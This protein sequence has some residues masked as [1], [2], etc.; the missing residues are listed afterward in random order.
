MKHEDVKIGMKV[1]PHSKTDSGTVE[2]LENSSIWKLAKSNNQSFLY[3]VDFSIENYSWV[4]NSDDTTAWTT[5]ENLF[6]AS[7]FEPYIEEKV[8]K[9]EIIVIEQRV[10][11]IE[12]F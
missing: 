11:E 6:N 7:D 12:F 10:K 5:H 2:F 3:V 9:K 1:V 8:I 4:L